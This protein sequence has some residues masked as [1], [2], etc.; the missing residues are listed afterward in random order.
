[1]NRLS[2]HTHQVYTGV[3]MVKRKD[4]GSMEMECFHELTHVTFPP[5]DKAVIES[6]VESGEPL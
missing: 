6:Y 5:L 3:A 2:G 1:M 4:E